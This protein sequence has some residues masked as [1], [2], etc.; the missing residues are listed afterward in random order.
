MLS[1]EF[2]YNGPNTEY[3][4]LA[5]RYSLLATAGA[6][7]WLGWFGLGAA[8]LWA[9]S[10]QWPP[11]GVYLVSL[12]YALSIVLLA[13]LSNFGGPEGAPILDFGF[14][15]LPVQFKIQNPK[16]KIAVSIPWGLAALA[17]LAAL[18]H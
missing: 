2:A 3:Q 7:R 1:T 8:P 11:A 5:T 6:V 16:S 18:L 15:R 4:V 12:V 17:L 10:E 13:G 14:R 9:L